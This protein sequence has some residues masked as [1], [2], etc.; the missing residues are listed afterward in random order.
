MS[1]T[2]KAPPEITITLTT[3]FG[4]KMPIRALIHLAE[5]ADAEVAIRYAETGT[6]IT[7]TRK[8]SPI[9]SPS[10]TELKPVI[11]AVDDIRA[12]TSQLLSSY[13][14]YRKHYA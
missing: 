8:V 5:E 2:K 12:L 7:F 6:E 11:D 3:K 1:K 14:I 4:E 9:T 10:F 13:L